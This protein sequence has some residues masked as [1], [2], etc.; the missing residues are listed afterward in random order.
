MK[1]KEKLYSVLISILFAFQLTGFAQI[2]SPDF[3]VVKLAKGV[4]A[5]IH[6]SGGR[7]ICN[8]GFVDLG[9]AT[10]VFDAFISPY[11]AEELKRVIAEMG[12]SPVKYVVNSHFHDD[13]IRGDQVFTEAS[14]YSTQITRDLIEKTEPKSIAYEKQNL[15]AYIAESDSLIALVPA[16]DPMQKNE[17]EFWKSYYETILESHTVL[18]TVLP[19]HI[20]TAKE[21]IKGSKLSVELLDLGMGHT[22]SDLILYIPRRDII[23]TGDL[24]FIQNHCW[25]AHGNP[26][27]LRHCLATIKD[28]NPAKLVPGHGPVGMKADIDVLLV[29][30]DHLRHEAQAQIESGMT[31]E[32]VKDIP[33][34]EAYQNWLLADFYIP[35]IQFQMKQLL[36]QK[37]KSE[38]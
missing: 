36:A 17:L 27:S 32:Q 29:Y 6:K 26:D 14:I 24:L 4:Y 15:A 3:E 20:V 34:P 19:D 18:H 11:A 25:I 2:S 35:N 8:A 7:A 10:L 37:S 16:D 31:P 21:I 22:A 5:A 13:H 33:V 28:M 30:L 9:D 38:P 23:F 12:L 1:A